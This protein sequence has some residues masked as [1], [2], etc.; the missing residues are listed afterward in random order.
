MRVLV[1]LAVIVTI[2]ANALANLLPLNGQT[3]GAVADRF[4][5]YFTPAG[6][7]FSIWSLIYAGLVGYAVLQLRPLEYS[8]P[9]LDAIAVPFV[10]SCVFNVAWLWFWHHEQF[11]LTMVMMVGLLGSLAFV[12]ARLGARAARSTLERWLVDRLFSLYLAWVTVATLANFAV[13][14][15]ADAAVPFRLD[16]PGWALV[17][18]GLAAAIGLAVAV[19]FR[20][21]VFIAVLVWA[22]IGI[23]VRPE[24]A[25]LVS[26]GALTVAALLVVIGAWFAVVRGRRAA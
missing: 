17:L 10:L 7:V 11:A 2:A 1:L 16:A 6:Y 3:T 26:Q 12:Y 20:D 22:A 4:Q 5:T 24:Q 13:L 21:L 23:A 19:R 9:R 18:L 14:L 15:R 8:N 25:P